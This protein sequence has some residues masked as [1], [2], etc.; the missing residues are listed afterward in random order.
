MGRRETEVP[1]SKVSCWPCSRAVC[2]PGSDGFATKD[3]VVVAVFAERMDTCATAVTA[4]P[5]DRDLWQ[6]FIGCVHAIR[7][8]QVADR[9]FSDVHRVALRR[10]PVV[11][12]ESVR[13]RLGGSVQVWERKTAADGFE[14]VG[15]RPVL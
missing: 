9:G 2:G 6:G 7:A 5:D 14:P 11:V 8:M 1:A 3:D 4:A 15:K 12:G 10:L 13:D